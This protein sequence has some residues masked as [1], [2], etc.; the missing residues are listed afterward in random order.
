MNSMLPP[1]FILRPPV[2]AEAQGVADLIAARDI[3][4]YGSTDANAEEVQNYWKAPLFDLAQDAR[5]IVAPDGL[6]VGYEEICPRSDQR[7]DYDGYVHPREAGRGFGTLLLRWAEER[8]CERLGEMRA[9]A[10]IV[11]HGNTPSVDQNARTMFNAEGFALVRQFWRMEI[12]MIAPPDRPV[13]PAGI[14][15]RTLR[16]EQDERSVHATIEE[17]FDD[18]WGHIPRSFEEWMK[19]IRDNQ[20]DPTL[21]F[22]A[23]EG[24][25]IAGV[26]VNRYRDIAW[27]GQLAV[28][29][30]W[31]KRGLGL[32]LLLQAFNE[33]YQRGDR[34]VGL[35]VDAQSLTG[36]TR[37]Y[38]KAGM[39]VTRQYDT[40]E[41]VI[42]E[43]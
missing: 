25:E 1:G 16:P 23:F 9:E 20:H 3:A 36:A 21:T 40:Y 30:P 7:L 28:R 24:E 41:K 11:L 32:A 35:G 26:A 43:E 29:R 39:R 8:A 27:V 42:R 14:R 19:W 34:A 38:E 4:D 15:V 33:F 17:A 18:H 5:I 31:R 22:I 2:M 6:I 37:L 13:W 12:E 10:R